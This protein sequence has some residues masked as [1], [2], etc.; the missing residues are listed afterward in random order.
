VSKA[1]ASQLAEQLK[2]GDWYL[3]YRCP[4]CET[5]HVLFR[6]LTYGVGE[7]RSTYMIECPTCQIKEAYDGQDLERYQ[8]LER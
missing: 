6:D 7:V 5:T 4:T 8:H 2:L 3:R 1:V